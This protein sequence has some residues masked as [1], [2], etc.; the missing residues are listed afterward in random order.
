MTSPPAQATNSSQNFHDKK[1]ML[2]AY[3]LW[4]FLGL[5]GAHLFYLKRKA[6][7]CFVL[8]FLLICI[9]MTILAR[10]DLVLVIHDP[11]HILSFLAFV[12]VINWI[13]DLFLIPMLAR[14][15]ADH[16]SMSVARTL[17]FFGGLAG[18]HRFY[19]GKLIS[20]KLMLALLST[21]VL[22]II[23]VMV[24]PPGTPNVGTFIP[25]SRFIIMLIIV[26]PCLA[27]LILWWIIDAFL[28]PY[29]VKKYNR[30]RHGPQKSI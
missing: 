22:G 8:V 12:L 2:K 26:G 6:T 30:P 21:L 11:S 17:W 5:S 24:T 19:L 23:L 20:A 25:D 10:H 1:T 4:L 18:L 14:P 15:A 27:M 13:S 7:A 9:A 28:T 16:K 3:V 29:M